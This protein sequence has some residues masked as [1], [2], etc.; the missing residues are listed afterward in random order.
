MTPRVSL[1]GEIILDLTLDDSALGPD[2]SVAGVT[3]PTFVQRTVTTR[4]RLRDGESNLL[5]GLLQTQDSNS[6]QGFPGAI[7]VPFFKQVFS[8][9]N[10]TSD[11]TEI[12]MLLTPHIVR[13]QELTESDLR[14]IYIGSQQ[15][16]GIGGPPPLIAAPSGRSAAPSGRPRLA[17][18]RR[19]RR[20]IVGPNGVTRRGAARVRRPCRARSS[21]RR[22]AQRPPAAPTPTPAPARARR[23]RERAAAQPPP[24]TPPSRSSCHQ[25]A[26]GAQPTI[27][28]QGIGS[29]QV[30]ISPPGTTFRVGGGPVHGSAVGD[31]RV[32][33]FDRHADARL[34]SRR[35]FACDRCR[36]GASCASA[37]WTSRSPS[38][39]TADASTSHRRAPRTRPAH[40]ARGCSPPSCSTRL[41]PGP[42]R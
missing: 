31:E 41:R 28:S 30:L 37:A 26:A 36:R 38:R 33:T 42:S 40:Q 27:T 8:G 23:R 16:L 19:R 20:S 6:V 25:R 12:V 39:S 21:C 11:Q 3:V 5:A 35:S 18:P 10:I 9:N 15:N 2:K 24:A 14:P 34:R 13:T 22:P 17:P 29:A 4:L 1:D 32:G 7:H